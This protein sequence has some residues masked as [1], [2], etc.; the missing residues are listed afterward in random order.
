MWTYISRNM[1]N[2][3]NATTD[4]ELPNDAA[5]EAF[6]RGE[7]QYSGVRKDG[8]KIIQAGALETKGPCVGAESRGHTRRNV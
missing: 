1:L 3:T 8:G 6:L 7:G 4:N 2:A 5:V